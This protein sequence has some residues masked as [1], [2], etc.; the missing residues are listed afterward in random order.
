MVLTCN[1]RPELPPDDEGTWRRVVLVEYKSRFKAEPLGKWISKNNKELSLE[2]HKENVNKSIL[3]DIWC[4]DDKN[5]PQFPIDETLNEKFDD[6]AEP[7]M[8]MLID[9]YIKNKHIDLREPTEVTEYTA[10]YRDQNNHFKEFV[11]DKII[12]TPENE[13]IVKI[14]ELFI[15]YKVWYKDNLGTT[16]GQKK[17]KDL[18][19]FMDNEY[20]NY[21]VEG[22][23]Y[24]KR[25]Y[26]G[27]QMV[28]HNTNSFI[29]DDELN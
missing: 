10:K 12:I 11:N 3:D 22:T 27:I 13:T 4:P 28:T 29:N 18:K 21:W 16:N 19:I 20:G 8:S 17:Q 24:T 6:W 23:S 14:E 1:D 15:E 25:G 9:T 7:F 5:N 2:E 26:R